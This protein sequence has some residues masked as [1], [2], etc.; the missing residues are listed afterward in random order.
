MVLIF[1]MDITLRQI[2]YFIATAETGQISR[3]ALVCNVTQSS[4]TTAI[5]GLEEQLGYKLF[6]RQSKGM[7]VT[8]LGERFLR[9]CHSIVRTV[10]DATEAVPD[11]PSEVSGVVK[12]GVTDTISGY[13]LP[14]IWRKL[15]RDYPEI[16]LEVL[17]VSRAELEAGLLDDNFDI[18]IMLTSN[19]RHRDPF[20]YE[21]LIASPRRLW[22]SS[23]H[24]LAEQDQVSI[25]DLATEDYILLTMDEHE[26]TM[27]NVWDL[28]DF[29]PNITFRSHTM[30]A[31][32]SM[33]AN[34]MGVAILSDMVYRSWSLEGR[35]IVK[36]D[37]IEDIPSMNT[38]MTWRRG[39]KLSDA[40]STFLTFLRSEV[41]A[42]RE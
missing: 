24:P 14:P 20:H 7:H 41:V 25:H 8:A 19:I 17:E 21:E 5:K 12:V 2:R 38:G 42:G 16:I 37:L 39:R 27:G 34:D 6:V 15:R 9:H 31:L 1:S 32:R 11:E 36:K 23:R 29:K 10:E 28:H 13:F 30:E 33:V 22:V 3:A 40:A 4:V 18:A 35:P 26:S